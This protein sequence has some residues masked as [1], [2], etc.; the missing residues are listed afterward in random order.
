MPFINESKEV[1]CPLCKGQLGWWIRPHIIT[2]DD[3]SKTHLPTTWM[4]CLACKGTGHITVLRTR[5][6][7]KEPRED[8]NDG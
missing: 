1:R 4:D 6:V 2:N 8:Q 5:W 7:F 3:G